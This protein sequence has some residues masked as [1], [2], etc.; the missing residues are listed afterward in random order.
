MVIQVLKLCSLMNRNKSVLTC[1]GGVILTYIHTSYQTRLSSNHR[2]QNPL[3]CKEPMLSSPDFQ[4]KIW[5]CQQITAL[6]FPPNVSHKP[7]NTGIPIPSNTSLI[8]RQRIE[9]AP[10]CSK[11][12]KNFITKSIALTSLK[13]SKSGYKVPQAWP[14][15]SAAWP[16]HDNITD[17]ASLD[18][19]PHNKHP[20]GTEILHFEKQK[21]KT[22]VGSVS[23][24]AHCMSHRSLTRAK[25]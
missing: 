20:L 22:S 23:Y 2:D 12:V 25:C 9:E 8:R 13:T 14:Q 4:I 18:A 7:T 6:V 17:V 15:F 5:P 19:F 11:S 3:M 1:L 24:C 21:Q 16:V 10:Q